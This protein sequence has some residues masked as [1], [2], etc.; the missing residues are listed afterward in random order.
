M[1]NPTFSNVSQFGTPQAGIQYISRPSVYAIIQNSDQ[2][3]AIVRHRG[4]YFLPGGGIEARETP[5]EALKREVIEETGYQIKDVA[6]LCET[7]EYLPGIS[8]EKYYHI[9]STFFV[10]QLNTAEAT[11]AEPD[12]Q[13]IWMKAEKVIPK[14]QRAA[15]VWAI[16]QFLSR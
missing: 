12:H 9:W 2:N 8:A 5:I 3:F 1:K 4:A 7:V 13:L 15:H 6:K 14:L 11:F 16:E 10:T